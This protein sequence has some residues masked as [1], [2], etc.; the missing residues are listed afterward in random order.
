MKALRML[1]TSDHHGIVFLRFAAV[2]GFFTLVYIIAAAL[3]AA[4]LNWQPM[5]A[6]FTA[7]VLNILPTYLS[8]RSLAFRSDAAHATAFWRYAVLQ[9][10]LVL[11]STSIT[12]LLI[13]RLKLS[14]GPAF[15]VIGILIAMVSF[16]LQRFWAFGHRPDAR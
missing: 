4:V 16:L 5:I 14:E 15:A 3:L 12:W 8:Q 9:A 7:H 6:N 1:L 13:D 11:M 10:P 2:G